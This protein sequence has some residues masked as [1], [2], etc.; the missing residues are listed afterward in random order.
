MKALMKWAKKGVKN[1]KI[2]DFSVLKT[3]TFLIG[4]IVGAYFSDFTKNYL[5]LWIVIIAVCFVRLM[6]LMFKK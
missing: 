4:M 2:W 1:F 3:Y 5:W 6:Y